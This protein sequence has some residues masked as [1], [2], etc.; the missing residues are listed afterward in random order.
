MN[1]PKL[2]RARDAVLRIGN[3]VVERSV[4]LPRREWQEFKEFYALAWKRSKK[5]TIFWTLYVGGGTAFLSLHLLGMHEIADIVAEKLGI[6]VG[7]FFGGILDLLKQ[8]F[9]KGAK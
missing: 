6:I 2:G 9:S 3:T 5:R 1:L 7:F 8:L 4:A